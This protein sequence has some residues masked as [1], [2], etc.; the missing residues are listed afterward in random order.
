MVNFKLV[1]ERSK[2]IYLVR[3]NSYID[4]PQIDPMNFKV[5]Y[6]VMS[7]RVEFQDGIC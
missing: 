7:F 4:L 2:H 6:D 3:V 1:N 5:E